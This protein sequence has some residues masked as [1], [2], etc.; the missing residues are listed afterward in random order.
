MSMGISEKGKELA[1]SMRTKQR[2]RLSSEELQ[3]RADAELILLQMDADQLYEVLSVKD[4][5]IRHAGSTG[6]REEQFFHDSASIFGD[7]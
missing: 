2:H 5:E 7:L 1:R 6:C 4:F 3:G